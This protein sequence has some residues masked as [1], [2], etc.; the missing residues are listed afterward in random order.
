M[1]AMA[2]ELR[3]QLRFILLGRTQLTRLLFVVHGRLA[4]CAPPNSSIQSNIAAKIAKPNSSEAASLAKG[5]MPVPV[6]YTLL[7]DIGATNARFVPGQLK[8]SAAHLPAQLVLA[9]DMS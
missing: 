3:S 5:Q 1:E 2:K 6:E 4:T 7:G 8:A 9:A